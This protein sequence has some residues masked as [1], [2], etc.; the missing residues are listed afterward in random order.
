[1]GTFDLSPLYRSTVGF[2]RLFALIDQSLQVEPAGWPPYNIEKLSGDSYRIQMAVAGFGPEDIEV[3]QH[4]NLLQVT[5]QKKAADTAEYLHR[6]IASRTFKQTFS[7][8]DHVKVVR[9]DLVNGMLSVDLVRDV[10]EE[11]KP[12]RI[13]I[14][15]AA[16]VAQD[17]VKQIESRAA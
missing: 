4:G 14:K 12:R 9:A 17:N 2:D 15:T 5:G 13:E 7:I 1:M 6:G 16:S 3:S 8:A 10:P 11:L